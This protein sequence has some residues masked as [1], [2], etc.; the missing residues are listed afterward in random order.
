MGADAVELTMI[1]SLSEADCP[2]L[3]HVMEYDVVLCGA[4]TSDPARDLEPL[5]PDVA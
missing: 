5:H 1:V 3:V 2:S 4:I